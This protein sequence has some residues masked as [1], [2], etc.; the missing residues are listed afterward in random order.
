MLDI[1]PTLL[2]RD[3]IGLCIGILSVVLVI[4]VVAICKWSRCL[5]LKH[6]NGNDD[7]NEA[8]S[9]ILQPNISTSD[10]NLRRHYQN[11]RY[12]V[13]PPPPPPQQQQQQQLSSLY[14]SHPGSIYQ[15]INNAGDDFISP[16]Q[17]SN[18][19]YRLSDTKVP[20]FTITTLPIQPSQQRVPCLSMS[21]QIS[22]SSITR[23]TNSLK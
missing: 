22:G 19:R 1:S 17:S 9:S 15:H 14:Q 6:H 8:F 13:H 7:Q 21:P 20:R 5:C 4:L 11:N 10:L 12:H 16:L 18:S 23:S 2:T 3:F